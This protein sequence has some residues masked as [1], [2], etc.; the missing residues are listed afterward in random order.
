MKEVAMTEVA[1]SAEPTG[2]LAG[3]RVVD[4]SQFESGTSCTQA[5]AWLGADVIKIEPPRR[6]EQGRFAS[7]DIAGVDSFYFIVLNANKRSVAI[8]LKTDDGRELLDGIIA[9]ADVFV[10]NFAP[11]AIE[12]MGFG[13]E[14]LHSI[15][16]RIPRY[17]GSMAT[18]P[19]T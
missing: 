15:N 8:D 10:E 7:T 9:D 17:P 4:L 5:L 2:A 19:S 13:Y 6:G 3:V 12:R 11:G 1:M 16:P 18:L 14:R